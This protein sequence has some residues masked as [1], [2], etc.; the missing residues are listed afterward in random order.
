MTNQ[1]TSTSAQGQLG[2]DELRDLV[3]SG[4]IDT[5]VVAITDSMGRLQGKRCGAR[6]FLEDVLGHGAEGC[7]YLLS[8]DVEMNTIDGYSMSSWANG[9]G[10]MVMRPDVATLRRVP[11]LEGTAMI[12]CDIF[13]LDGRP[14][15][16]SPRQILRAQIE[17]LEALGYRAHI[18]TELEFIMFDD[19]YEEAWDK[20]YEGLTPSTRYNVDYSLLATARLEPVIRSI[21]TGMEKAGLVVESSKGECNLGQQEITFRYAEA[22]TACDNH[23]FY[24]NGAK[25]IAAQQG[26]SITFM[27]KYNEREGSSCHIHFSLTDLDGNP[28]LAGDGEHGFSPVMEHFIAGQLAGLKELAYF[29]APNINSYKR[30]VEGS[31]AP[32]AIAWGLDNRSCALRIVG[33][34]PSLRV[35]N[36][37]GG[38]DVNPYLAAAA[39]IAAA[40]HGIENELPLEPI[41]TG[42]AYQSDADRIPT[43]LRDSRA[44]LTNS[45]IARKSFGDDVVDHYVFAADV[46]LKAFDSTVT[47]WERKRVFE[48]L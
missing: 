21:R 16:Q 19:S 29:V 46:E 6:S 39:L 30:F 2:V 41:M 25:E 18:G 8:V 20:K 40:I 3:A 1:T 5:V 43:N 9:Y 31:F 47:D 37:V 22:L 34:G 32:T 42:N 12:Q 17:R 11:W 10:D 23:V 27:A 45:E 35:E 38:G 48:R 4:D 15:S 7:N 14:V 13:W 36:R 24:K 26:K 33:R 28:V 44:L